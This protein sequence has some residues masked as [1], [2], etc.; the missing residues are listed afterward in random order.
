[1]TDPLQKLVSNLRNQKPVKSLFQK[2]KENL[3]TLQFTHERPLVMMHV[4]GSHEDT[5]MKNGIRYLIKKELDNRIKMVAGPGCPVCVSPVQDIDFSVAVSDL[6]NTIITSYGDMIRVPGSTRS[7]EMQRQKGKDVLAVYSV[8]DA[9]KLAKRKP[10]KKVIFISPGFET[11]TPATAI[12]VL[13]NPPN[14]FFVLPSHRLVPPA[15]EILMTLPELKIDAFILPGHVSVII[16]ANAY[17]EFVKHHRKPSAIAG[18]EPVDMLMGISSVIQQF[19]DDNPHVANMY[20]RAVTDEG[21]L[22]AQQSMNTVFEPVSAIWRGLGEF[23]GSGLDFRSEFSHVSAKEEFIGQIELETPQ[24]IPKGCSCHRVVIGAIEPEQ[25]P[26][27][28]TRCTPEKP[29]GPCMVGLEGTCRIRAIYGE[30]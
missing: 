26:L 29:V 9:V 20:G 3:D 8:I 5:L 27:Y 2:M 14:N 10:D 13:N 25:C 18:F 1:M 6:P 19:V 16:G 17:K 30:V 4:C 24:E 21:N 7:L 23:K 15:L 22:I 11:T 28:M 12:E